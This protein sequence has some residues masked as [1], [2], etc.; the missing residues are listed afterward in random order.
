MA[1]SIQRI[2]K[3]RAL[4]GQHPETQGEIITWLEATARGWNRAPTPFVWGGKRQ[5][6]RQRAWQR[7]HPLGGSGACA[8]QPLS[9]NQP[10]QDNGNAQPK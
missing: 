2:F 5:A 9:T 8:N 7:R 4:D 1:E 6:R 3:H 10:A